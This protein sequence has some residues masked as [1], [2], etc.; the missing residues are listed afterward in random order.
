MGIKEAVTDVKRKVDL[1]AETE[2]IDDTAV[3]G[4]DI[5]MGVA[6][7]VTFNI[8]AV[9]FKHIVHIPIT[10]PAGKIDDIPKTVSLITANPV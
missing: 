9:L 10:T 8:V 3:Y 1:L 4:Q 5:V 2:S 6:P 7:A